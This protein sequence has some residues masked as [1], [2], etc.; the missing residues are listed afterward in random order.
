MNLTTHASARIQQRGVSPLIVEWLLEFGA[1]EPA[2]GGA[3]RRY[4]DKAARRRLAQAFGSQ[5]VDRLG[6][7]LSTYLVQSNE[8]DRVITVGHRLKR[9][10]N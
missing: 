6:D 1:E 3:I 8:G 9:C 4:F 7:L 2:P 5:V 10:R